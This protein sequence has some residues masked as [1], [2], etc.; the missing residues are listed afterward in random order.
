MTLVEAKEMVLETLENKSAWRARAENLVE[1]CRDHGDDVFLVINNSWGKLPA[2]YKNL[3]HRR[4]G[5]TAYNYYV[6]AVSNTINK[7]TVMQHETV[8]L[9][10]SLYQDTLACMKKLLASH[11]YLV[12]DSGGDRNK[13]SRVKEAKRIIKD[14]GMIQKKWGVA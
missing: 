14:L 12:E 2:K 7:E 13:D 6:W 10:L 9:E 8:V 4:I 1:F 5:G 11:I 3:K